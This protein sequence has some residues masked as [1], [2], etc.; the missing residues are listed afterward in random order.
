VYL[1]RTRI[2][3]AGLTSWLSDQTQQKVKSVISQ[4]TREIQQLQSNA[5]TS[6]LLDEHRLLSTIQGRAAN[7]GTTEKKFGLAVVSLLQ[8]F[9]FS[10][11][12]I[13]DRSLASKART[14]GLEDWASTLTTYRGATIHEGYMDFEKK[15][16]VDD[17]AKVCLH[18]KDVIARLIFKETQYD[19]TY[20]SPLIRE[21]G[22]QPI[23]WVQPGTAAEKLGFA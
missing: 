11:A 19:G 23:S 18:L 21:F 17:V 10:D 2:H 9:G 14:D 22:P 5:R 4:A 13:I 3:S 15:H 16:D 7:I 6:G 20:Q 12:D 1:P 8:S